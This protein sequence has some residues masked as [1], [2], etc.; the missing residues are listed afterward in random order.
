MRKN[1]RDSRFCKTL[2]KPVLQHGKT[3]I[4]EAPYLAINLTPGCLRRCIEANQWGISNLQPTLQTARLGSNVSTEHRHTNVEN[5]LIAETGHTFS[6][7]RQTPNKK[8][9]EKNVSNSHRNSATT[10][11]KAS[12]KINS[13]N[14]QTLDAR[15]SRQSELTPSS[16]CAL[17]SSPARER[18]LVSEAPKSKSSQNPKPFRAEVC[19]VIPPE[20][21]IQT[22]PECI[23]FPAT[24]I[25]NP[26]G[27]GIER[28]LTGGNKRRVQ[29]AC[30]EPS[31]VGELESS[32]K[33]VR[34]TLI[35]PHMEL[36]ALKMALVVKLPALFSPTAVQMHAL[37]ADSR[38]GT[39][40][41]GT[42]LCT[43]LPTAAA[44]C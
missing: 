41:P 12:E 10:T 8:H 34:V 42:L 43:V 18:S 13:Q 31:R 25:H 26:G 15:P 19:S 28:W 40:H 2:H 37:G 36:A 29:A 3:N 9:S 32:R 5:Q 24:H 27:R 20:S 17:V 35:V 7:P 4:F 16:P 11:S 14:P 38:S 21:Q 22:L 44:S 23:Q 39:Q 33:Q 1:N 6:N 30:R